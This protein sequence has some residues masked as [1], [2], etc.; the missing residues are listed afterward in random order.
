MASLSENHDGLRG[1]NGGGNNVRAV[2]MLAEI[3][4]K[5]PFFPLFQ[6]IGRLFV[7]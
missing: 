2:E 7:D 5:L 3:Q 1:K 6:I 4:Q